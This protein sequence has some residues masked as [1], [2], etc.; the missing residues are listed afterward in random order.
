MQRK[1]FHRALE[2]FAALAMVLELPSAA[3]RTAAY[4]E[5]RPYES[6]GKGGKRPHRTT[7]IAGVRRAATKRRNQIRNRKAHR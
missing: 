5:L 6:R 2:L 3:A 1:P 7:G 4:A